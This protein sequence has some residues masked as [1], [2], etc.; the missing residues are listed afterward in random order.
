MP[1]RATT[2][3]GPPAAARRRRTYQDMAR[4]AAPPTASPRPSASSLVITTPAPSP[5]R[6]RAALTVTAAPR[7]GGGPRRMQCAPTR[8]DTVIVV[9]A[10]PYALAREAAAAVA[11]RTGVERHDAV[12]VL[13]S[14]WAGAVDALGEVV[15]ELD[16]GELPGFLPPV[17][18]GHAGRLRSTRMGGR[19]VLVVLG[20][21]HLYEGHGPGPVVHAVRAAAAAGCRTA[22]LT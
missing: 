21:T 7:S 14:G 1:S 9:T 4:Y 22:V 6:A 19:A 13:G 8:P 10:D 17:A 11:A 3:L 2:R 15:A 20:R 16:V 12:V 18:Q 5:L